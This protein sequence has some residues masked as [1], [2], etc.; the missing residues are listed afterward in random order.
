MS[1]TTISLALLLGMQLFQI[2]DK[3]IDK[4]S[5]SECT[6]KGMRVEMKHK[7]EQ[8]LPPHESTEKSTNKS[9]TESSRPRR[10]RI[11]V[12]SR[13]QE[14]SSGSNWEEEN[15][16]DTEEDTDELKTI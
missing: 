8:E 9:T 5:S 11:Q 15:S 14:N 1:F 2:V 7:L 6:N 3:L 16:Y 12:S 4:L 13:S 10:R